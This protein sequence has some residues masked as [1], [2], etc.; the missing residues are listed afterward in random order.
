MK[1][2]PLSPRFA[3]LAAVLALAA[4]SAPAVVTRAPDS[5]PQLSQGTKIYRVELTRPTSQ[6]FPGL[7]PATPIEVHEVKGSWVLVDSPVIAR[8]PIWLN[9]E[10]VTQYAMQP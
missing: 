6:L 1:V 2:L 7:G 4:V 10:Q 8:G 3:A 5:P 9:F